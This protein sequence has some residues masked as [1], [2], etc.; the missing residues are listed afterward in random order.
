LV[1]I[2]GG[3]PKN[4]KTKFGWGSEMGIRE[5]TALLSS[6]HSLLALYALLSHHE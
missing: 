3:D 4:E 6:E 2:L 5:K 1:Y